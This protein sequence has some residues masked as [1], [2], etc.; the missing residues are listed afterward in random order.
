MQLHR[1]IYIIFWEWMPSHLL[2]KR[3]ASI[4]EA[5][6]FN[7]GG[8]ASAVTEK[9]TV[10]FSRNPSAVPNRFLSLC[11]AGVEVG[12]A[13]RGV[14]KGRTTTQNSSNCPAIAPVKGILPN[15]SVRQQWVFCQTSNSELRTPN[16]SNWHR[17]LRWCA[18]NSRLHVRQYCVLPILELWTPYSEL[19]QL[20]M[21]IALAGGFLVPFCR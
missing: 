10:R 16:S 12:R 8:W 17:Q 5:F 2:E 19:K 20:T 15:F 7:S 14:S 9:G 3:K 11:W 6:L 21:S 18:A 1:L 4:W 13:M